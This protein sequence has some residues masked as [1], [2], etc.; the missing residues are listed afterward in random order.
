[1]LRII[2]ANTSANINLPLDRILH[3]LGREI[4]T[5]DN[6]HTSVSPLGRRSESGPP[7]PTEV[8]LPALHRQ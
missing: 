6:G 5:A 8:H 1:M 4:K 3:F 7:L 2:P